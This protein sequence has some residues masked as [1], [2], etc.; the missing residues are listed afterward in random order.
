MKRVALLVLAAL[1]SGPAMAA[2]PANSP[3][4]PVRQEPACADW[5]QLERYRVEN[6]RAGISERAERRVV[7]FGDSITEGWVA[8]A[9]DFF[10]GRAYLGRGIRGQTT[11]QMLV[12]FRQDVI[13]LAP[14][15]VVILAGT[16]DI[17]GN[18]GP[19]REE[20]TF[21][22]LKTMVELAAAHGIR[23]VVAS[24]LPVRDYP[25][26]PGLDPAPKVARL[27]GLLREY[28]QKSGAIYLDYYSAMADSL[29]G[30]KPNLGDD[31][32]HPNRAGYEVMAA[33][34]E[35]ALQKALAAR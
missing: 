33:L 20:E 34:A 19:Y 6:A 17:A 18:T 31:G 29:G 25:W 12:R 26:A 9:P 27:N 14:R 16:N 1:G 2:G 11:S 8:V 3:S 23:A 10:A 15:A 5:A 30:L 4:A 32:V 28:A 21:A 35:K 24:V 13:A 22:N 7:F